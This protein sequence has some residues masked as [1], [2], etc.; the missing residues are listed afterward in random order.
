MAIKEK[1]IFSPEKNFSFK[2]SLRLQKFWR[3]RKIART[4]DG[5]AK[6]TKSPVVRTGP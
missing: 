1:R 3:V 2:V 6:E 4:R 5:F